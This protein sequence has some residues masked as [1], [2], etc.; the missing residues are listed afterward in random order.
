ML[1][2]AKHY[3]DD[4]KGAPFKFRTVLL[5]RAE[6]YFEKT[7]QKCDLNEKN[8]SNCSDAEK[9]L[10]EEKKAKARRRYFGFFP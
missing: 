8:L 1:S 10:A 2:Y 7:D 6:R 5:Q 4:D 3:Y 9:T